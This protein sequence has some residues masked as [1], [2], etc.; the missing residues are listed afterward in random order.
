TLYHSRDMEAGYGIHPSLQSRRRPFGADHGL[1]ARGQLS[2]GLGGDSPVF[3]GGGSRPQPPDPALRAGGPR[4]EQGR[5]VAAQPAARERNA[6]ARMSEREVQEVI[7]ALEGAAGARAAGPGEPDARSDREGD[8]AAL[9]WSPPRRSRRAR[10][11][12]A[13][14]PALL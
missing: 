12:S 13:A 2:A 5:G 1:R 11:R 9:A 4:R 3:V 8:R 14:E 6:R 10:H 7:A